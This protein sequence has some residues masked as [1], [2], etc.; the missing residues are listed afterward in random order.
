M[1]LLWSV[2]T[3]EEGPHYSSQM[4]GFVMATPCLL[5]LPSY[6]FRKPHH[7]LVLLQVYPNLLGNQTHISRNLLGLYLLTHKIEKL[8]HIWL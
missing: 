4:L 2:S 7:T 3:R 1:V 5:H 8:I 6:N